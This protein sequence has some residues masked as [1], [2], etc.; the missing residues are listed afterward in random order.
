MFLMSVCVND[1][2]YSLGHFLIGFSP[3][4]RHALSILPIMIFLHGDVSPANVTL[5][6]KRLRVQPYVH[7]ALSAACEETAVVMGHT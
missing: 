7:Q 6:P 5:T 4:Y 2:V 1:R 3:Y